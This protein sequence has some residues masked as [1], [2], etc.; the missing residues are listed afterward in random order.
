MAYI[1]IDSN[2]AIRKLVPQLENPQIFRLNFFTFADFPQMLQLAELRL[3]DNIFICDFRTQ[4]FFTD[5][6]L[7]Q[8]YHFSHY[9][10]QI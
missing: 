9:K 2:W 4:L 3:A 6:K 1:Q 8:I 7:Q 5:L 10:L